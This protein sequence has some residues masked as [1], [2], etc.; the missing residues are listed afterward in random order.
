MIEQATKVTLVDDVIRQIGNMIQTGQWVPGYQLPPERQLVSDFGVSRN[1]LREALKALSIMGVLESKQGGGNFVSHDINR[2]IFT[3]SL[4]FIKLQDQRSVFDLLEARRTIEVRTAYLAAQRV[5][6]DLIHNLK[7]NNLK[8]IEFIKDPDEASK[9]DI[10]F[11]HHIA[12]ATGNVFYEEIIT[13][14]YT[15]T[16]SLM[17]ETSLMEDLVSLSADYHA[18]I[19]AAIINRD[20]DGAAECMDRHLASVQEALFN[21]INFDVEDE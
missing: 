9:Y 14:L 6:P 15:P 3:A 7:Q 12:K 20:P 19:L 1:T 11:H 5:T 17:R 21:V 4:K 18:Q 13:T 8:I 10:N 2:R 16:V